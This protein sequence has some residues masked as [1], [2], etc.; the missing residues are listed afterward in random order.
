MA[1][2]NGHILRGG[3]DSSM[4][5]SGAENGNWR[6]QR[7][8]QRRE[9]R[10]EQRRGYVPGGE[11]QFLLL[12]PNTHLKPHCGTTNER[13]TGEWHPDLYTALALHTTLH[14]THTTHCTHTAGHLGLLVPDSA[15]GSL[16]L[17]VANETLRW[18]EGGLLFFDDSFEHEVWYNATPAHAA[19]AAHA[20]VPAAHAPHAPHA[21][22][23]HSTLPKLSTLPAAHTAEAVP[24]G[25]PALSATAAA[26]TYRLVLYFSMW[27]PQL[28]GEVRVPLSEEGM[29][30]G[31]R[32]EEREV[33]EGEREEEGVM[34]E[35]GR[36]EEG[37]VGEGGR[38]EEGA[39]GEGGREEEGV[40]GEEGRGEEG[41]GSGRR[42]VVVEGGG[43]RYDGEEEGGREGQHAKHVPRQHA[44]I[45]EEQQEQLYDSGSW[46]HAQLVSSRSHSQLAAAR[47]ASFLRD[48]SQQSQQSQQSH[49]SQQLQQSQ[50]SQHLQPP[51]FDPVLSRIFPRTVQVLR[52]I[53][54]LI[55]A[56]FSLL[57]PGTHIAPHCGPTTRRIRL[58]LPLVMRNAS[59]C[60]IRVGGEE[61][62]W[63]LGRVLAFD[64]SFEHEIWH[65]GDLE[66]GTST[67]EQAADPA[68]LFPEG[69]EASGARLVLLVDLHHPAAAR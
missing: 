12:A 52:Q 26:S 21:P 40:L 69:M 3:T 4:D 8:A 43:E 1:A 11:V 7:R 23:A 59:C 37:V 66:P 51:L 33:G 2:T 5:K 20:A 41:R 56:K 16:S 22:H 53:P 50:Q 6:G 25:A 64:D 31:R 38:G 45:W 48:W 63:Q 32:E 61:Q 54:N 29:G 10:R 65:E 13:I 49:Q 47:S 36:R 57:S 34:G 60:R 68:L 58:H 30:E 35:G 67:G 42:E 28:W 27:H 18:Q 17:R 62:R 55:A 14:C 9:Q 19:H 44:P 46:R 15:V 39:V 24:A